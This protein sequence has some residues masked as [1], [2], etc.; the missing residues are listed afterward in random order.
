MT[1][2]EAIDFSAVMRLS[3][4]SAE[5]I[6]R[7]P[8]VD[9]I[10]QDLEL[11]S[12]ANARISTLRPGELKC[13]S[14][15][16]ELAAN[17]PVLLLD[18]PTSGLDARSAALVVRVLRNVAN[19]DRKDGSKNCRTVI[20]TIHQPSAEVLALFDS[21]LLLHAGGRIAYF[22]KLG[23]G[24]ILLREHFEIVSKKKAP[25]GKSPINWALEL[26]S[27]SESG[28]DSVCYVTAYRDIVR[29]V[30]MSE[31]DSSVY[32]G[33][34]TNQPLLR[35]KDRRSFL[36]LFLSLQIRTF[37]SISRDHSY[38]IAR[39]GALLLVSLILGAV[40]SRSA[41]I[42][43]SGDLQTRMGMWFTAL[44]F[45]STVHFATA[46][47]AAFT[48]RAVFNR[49]CRAGN[50]YSPEAF[51]LTMV[52]SEI[53]WIS[54]SILIFCAIFYTLAQ[55]L[56]G[57]FWNFF[58]NALLL[59]LSLNALAHLLAALSPSSYS[60]QV[61]GYFAIGLYVLFGG[62]FVTAPAIPSNLRFLFLLNPMRHAF[63]SVS[64]TQFYCAEEPPE[65][66]DCS[67][68]LIPPIVSPVQ[69]WPFVRNWLGLVRSTPMDVNNIAGF[70]IAFAVAAVL[71]PRW[72]SHI[73]R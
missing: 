8:F 10:V 25:I 61:L 23:I 51:G 70:Y 42:L 54:C 44:S 72:V 9:G 5:P 45:S 46:L 21:L 34:K 47:P 56:A 63:F 58:L 13:L 55:G 27:D 15:G 16:V 64:A 67:S 59:S 12:C 41:I 4:A 3:A 22:G 48:R 32:E 57:A 35:S 39:I 31:S 40:Y 19:G 53:P 52:I 30:I 18:E 24:S 60:A 50:M 20:A 28:Q 38:N 37:I 69:L 29:N 7:K 26:L 68:F 66:F 49:E 1:V 71:A 14:I 2:R 17:R 36:L 65:S 73:K 43:V 33:G 62:L 6:Y 11:E